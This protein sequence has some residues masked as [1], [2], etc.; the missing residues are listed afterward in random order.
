MFAL[1]TTAS[2]VL[3][4]LFWGSALLTGGAALDPRTAA[5]IFGWLCMASIAVGVFAL[6][7]GSDY[8]ELSPAFAGAL[9]TTLVTG[10]AILYLAYFE[11][12]P[13][14]TFAVAHAAPA[15]QGLPERPLTMEAPQ[16]V[17]A[18]PRAEP[19]RPRPK[20][21]PALAKVVEACAAF[22]GVEKQ[23]CR[24]CGNESGISGF[25]CRENARAEYCAG[26][27]GSEPGCPLV[28]S[29]AAD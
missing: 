24:R 23:Q 19:S 15:M 18:L 5:L 16:N 27:D 9:A 12:R 22:K 21:R 8:D 4:G 29:A 6:S 13:V 7:R 25:V 2:L 11:W 14:A 20:A 26:R 3:S 10:A 28:R 1:F 17:A